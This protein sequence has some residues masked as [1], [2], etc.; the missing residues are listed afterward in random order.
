VELGS[1]SK[2][3]SVYTLKQKVSAK[4]RTIDYILFF[5]VVIVILITGEFMKSTI[6]GSK[7]QKD[8]S[9]YEFD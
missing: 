8:P 9:K 3:S 7:A 2:F 6:L 5:I 4:Y 1:S